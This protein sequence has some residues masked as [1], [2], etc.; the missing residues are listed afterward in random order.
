MKLPILYFVITVSLAVG[1]S[2]VPYAGSVRAADQFLPGASIT[3]KQGSTKVVAYTDEV[4]GR[5][6]LQLAPGVWEMQVEMFGFTT[7]HE[8]LRVNDGEAIPF[9]N[10]ALDDM[11]RLEQ[12]VSKTARRGQCYG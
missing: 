6:T 8:T 5:Y 11:P 1:A 7:Q 4:T 10:W 9:K 2:T 12:P 3:A